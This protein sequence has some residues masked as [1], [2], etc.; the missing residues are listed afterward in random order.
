MTHPIRLFNKEIPILPVPIRIWHVGHQFYVFFPD[1][2]VVRPFGRGYVMRSVAV[3]ELVQRKLTVLS[4]QTLLQYL[5]SNE[6]PL[7]I[8]SNLADRQ[9]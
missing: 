9:T 2:K 1:G 7:S 5:Y 3:K 4:T 8:G 6:C